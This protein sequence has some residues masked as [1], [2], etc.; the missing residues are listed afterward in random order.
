[1]NSSSNVYK[2]KNLASNITLSNVT[3]SNKKIKSFLLIFPTL[4]VVGLFL[5][6]VIP[7]SWSSFYLF[8]SRNFINRIFAYK[9]NFIF[10]VLYVSISFAKFIDFRK[11]T[12]MSQLKKISLLPLPNALDTKESKRLVTSGKKIL[13]IQ[14]VKF[15]LKNVILYLD[16]WVID[17]IFVWTGGACDVTTSA[18]KHITDAEQCRKL[19]GKWEGGFDI[20]GHFCFLTSVSLILFYEIHEICRFYESND[21][22]DFSPFTKPVVLAI[23]TTL[24][25]WCCLLFVTSIFYHTLMEKILGLAMGYICSSVIYSITR[26]SLVK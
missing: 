8:S 7:A 11:A 16:F 6:L 26:L 24:Y 3:I 10:T 13:T 17:H 2:L 18:M 20:S 4:L 21:Y 9:G 19:S 5:S 14:L 15:T 23:M 22:R 12:N 25:V 1:M